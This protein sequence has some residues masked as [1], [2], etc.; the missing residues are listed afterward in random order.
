MAAAG[1]IEA[2]RTPMPVRRRGGRR[3]KLTLLGGIGLALL[4]VNIFL[5]IS[6][7]ALAP[8]DPGD[9]VAGVF[10]PPGSAL[11]LGS[12]YLGRDLLSRLL[13]GAKFSLGLAGTATCLGFLLG[14]SLGFSAAELRGRFDL[15]VT[16]AIDVLLSFP[17][18]LLAL[19]IIAGLGSS[20]PVLIGVI[21]FIQMPRVA[22]VARS[23]AMGI[24]A[25]DFVEVARSR[26]ESLVSILLREILP[27]AVRPLSVEFGLRLSFAVLFISSL[28][29][30]G[31]GIQPP[32]A[33]WGTMVRENLSGIYY[34]A[35]AAIMPA[36][37]IGFLV[38]GLN[39]TVDWL[40]GGA[41]RHI[42]DEFR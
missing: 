31:L 23:I 21:A 29:F 34:G 1:E 2:A 15:L 10:A 38:V 16:W 36:L 42:A 26:G 5:A 40:G 32:E 27:N 17:P 14:I 33:D 4:A 41:D 25:A 6:G 3:R 30:L 39:L 8:N 11:P 19:L 12:D 13:C 35:P 22:R 9:L 7:T 28:S 37:M 20:L 24:A 18:I